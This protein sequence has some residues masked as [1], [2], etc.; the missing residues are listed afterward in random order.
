MDKFDNQ[1]CMAN[2]DSTSVEEVVAN[3]FDSDFENQF[4]DGGPPACTISSHF[5]HDNDDHDQDDDNDDDDNINN[6]GDDNDDKNNDAN[7]NNLVCQMHR[8][9]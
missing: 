9:S 6:D 1:N 7:D 4:P 3:G 5:L 2:K 8:N